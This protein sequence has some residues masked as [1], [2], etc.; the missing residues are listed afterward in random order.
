MTDEQVSNV[1]DVNS[2]QAEPVLN[3]EAQVEQVSQPDK[4]APKEKLVPQSK[5][6][7]IVG[8]SKE[9]AY[10]LGKKAALLELQ[11][12]FDQESEQP[13]VDDA[14][15]LTRSE[16]N[17]LIKEREEQKEALARREAVKMYSD[18]IGQD[19]L[20]KVNTDKAKY[21][22]FEEVTADLDFEN[23]SIWFDDGK[24]IVPNKM[25]ELL[26]SVDNP[27]DVLYEMGKNPEKAGSITSLLNT[28]NLAKKALIKL[29]ESIK[30]NQKATSSK[31]KVPEPYSQVKPSST[32][33][34]N[35]SKTISD[36]RKASYLRA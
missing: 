14:K 22:D 26:N 25:L 9:Q 27:G 33:I 19:L 3:N 6:N 12:Q 28:P 16:I 34:D 2:S 20:T 31:T 11:R 23:T 36:L 30:T 5:V 15:P 8:K 24:N 17:R 7:E 18:K 35:G 21:E 1:Q 10:E 32:G 13:S 4:E 29:S